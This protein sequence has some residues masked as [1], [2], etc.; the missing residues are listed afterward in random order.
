MCCFSSSESDDKTVRIAG[1]VYYGI[2]GC[3][4]NEGSLFCEML[5]I[6]VLTAPN[7]FSR[8]K[9]KEVFT[10]RPFHNASVQNL[11][12]MKLRIAANRCKNER[13]R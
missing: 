3:S 4:E 9:L 11:R 6:M 7:A 13:D 5:L 10:I 12:E 2:R 8:K 1:I